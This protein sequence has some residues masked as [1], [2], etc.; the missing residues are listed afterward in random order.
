MPAHN[1]HSQSTD[2]RV[3]QLLQVGDLSQDFLAHVQHLD[4]LPIDD[5][6]RDLLPGA[7][8]LTNC[9]ETGRWDGP[10]V[11][12]T[13]LAQTVAFLGPRQ[14]QTRQK[15]PTTPH[16]RHK[17]VSFAECSSGATAQQH[18]PAGP[19]QGRG[20]G[21]QAPTR[22]LHLTKRSKAER[23]GQLVRPDLQ[24]RHG[25]CYY[26]LSEQHAHATQR[27]PPPPGTHECEGGTDLLKTVWF[28]TLNWHPA[29][30][31]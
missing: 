1:R 3:H 19:T 25:G 29:Q 13:T 27:Q 24:L 2:V 15:Q 22:T 30:A 23:L 7:V 12:P 26:P 17:M 28:P 20:V 9:N 5:L 4:L 16:M 11:E 10:R 14:R 8:M 18:G 21:A 31:A 6:D